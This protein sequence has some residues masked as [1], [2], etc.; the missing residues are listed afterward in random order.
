[1]E[2]SSAEQNFP[3]EITWIRNEVNVEINKV[4]DSFQTTPMGTITYTHSSWTGA[5][6]SRHTHGSESSPIVQG[7]VQ[8]LN[9]HKT[10][11]A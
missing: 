11:G 5:D 6:S 4:G 1:V 8:D 7:L 9:V 3:D 10:H 2:T